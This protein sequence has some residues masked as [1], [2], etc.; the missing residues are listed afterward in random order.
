MKLGSRT[1]VVALIGIL[2]VLTSSLSQTVDPGSA[3]AV[4]V[5]VSLNSDGSRTVYEFD[6]LHHKA[7]ATT[8]AP[9]GRVIGKILYQIDDAGR[10]SS[11]VILGP[12][13]RF[14]F[15][16]LYKYDSSGRLQEETHLRK[17]DSVINKFV[18]NYSP[19]GRQTGYS[20]YDSSGKLIA[21]STSPTP[22]P[23]FHGRK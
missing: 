3:D 18:Y 23:K 19:T 7:T 16:S 9:E 13:D 6:N 11:G 5:R 12:E 8:T 10:F 15:K 1:S 2:L 22:T 14:Q 20:I 17:D 4:R 21:G